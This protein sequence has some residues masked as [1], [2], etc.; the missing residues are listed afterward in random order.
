MQIGMPVT[1]RE[2]AD[3]GHWINEPQGIDDT[4]KF[5]Q[6]AMSKSDDLGKG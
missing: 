6:C 5:L 3:G 4:V 1:W 2:Y